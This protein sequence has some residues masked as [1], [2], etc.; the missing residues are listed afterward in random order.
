MAGDPAPSPAGG[1]IAAARRT[2]G[3]I[4]HA[5]YVYGELRRRILDNEFPPGLQLLESEVSQM[6]NVSRTPVREALRRLEND[7]LIEVRPRRGMR[8]LPVSPE[9]MRE[10]YEILTSLETTAARLVA[11]RGA[12]ARQF[13]RLRGAVDD[14]AAALEDNDLMR[15]ADADERF[16]AELIRASGNRRLI[17]IGQTLL[18]QAR[19]ARIVTLKLR[20]FPSKSNEDHTALVDA[21]AAQDPDRAEAIHHSHRRR[22]MDMLVNLLKH[23]KLES[24]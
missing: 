12:D 17:Q 5:D 18:D 3:G 21:I 16:H 19:R 4:S 23:H 7:G 24:V 11:E 6:L 15:W 2:R 10:I 22:S 13:K 8:V 1:T 14:M 9:D 20:P